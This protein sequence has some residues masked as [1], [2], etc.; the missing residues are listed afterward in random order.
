MTDTEAS[1]TSSAERFLAYVVKKSETVDRFSGRR[2]NVDRNRRITGSD[3]LFSHVAELLP[4][5]LPLKS[6]PRTP[7]TPTTAL[8]KT[9]PANCFEAPNLCEAVEGT[10]A[11]T[12][13]PPKIKGLPKKQKKGNILWKLIPVGVVVVAIAVG[14]LWDRLPSFEGAAG[15]A[16]DGSPEEGGESGLLESTLRFVL[17]PVAA[18]RV[19]AYLRCCV[20]TWTCGVRSN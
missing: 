18:R 15:D 20:F 1:S 3:Q 14:M 19:V 12:K 2:R 5:Q 16:K 4:T 10:M 17:V 11:T 13:R 8:C 6:Q 7:P 9:S